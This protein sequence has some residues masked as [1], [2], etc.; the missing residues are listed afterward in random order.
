MSFTNALRTQARLVLTPCRARSAL[1]ALRPLVVHQNMVASRLLSTSRRL[2]F[3]TESRPPNPRYTRRKDRGMEP[4]PPGDTLFVGGL[5]ADTTEEA[6]LEIFKDFGEITRVTVGN[7]G[8]TFF[9]FFLSFQYLLCGFLTLLNVLGPKDGDSWR[10]KYA[11]V[12]FKNM[13]D[14]VATYESAQEEPIVVGGETVRVGYSP[15]RRASGNTRPPPAPSRQL[16]FG[17]NGHPEVLSEVLEPFKDDIVKTVFRECSNERVLS[18]LLLIL[19]LDFSE[20]STNEG[21]HG[22]GFHQL[23]RSRGCHGCLYSSSRDPPSDSVL[24]ALCKPEIVKDL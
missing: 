8:S 15:A 9:F 23:Q 6:V 5:P 18:Y 20:G 17:R 11:H 1:S 2:C 16:F 10:A 21:I 14:S 19:F 3:D 13:D 4:Y 22:T 7:A 12:Q 24:Y